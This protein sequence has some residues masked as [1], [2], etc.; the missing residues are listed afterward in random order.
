MR[1]YFSIEIDCIEHEGIEG[2]IMFLALPSFNHVPFS[3]VGSEPMLTPVMPCAQ[4][5]NS[6]GLSIINMVCLRSRRTTN[7]ASSLNN[8]A[9]LQSVTK[10]LASGIL[11]FPRR[12]RA[13]S[14]IVS[15]SS[16]QLITLL[17]LS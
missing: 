12:I 10:D 8:P 5:N 17:A 11:L 2:I 9:C 13:G 4:P 7:H 14:T 6:Q 1:R 16:F 15:L 3:I